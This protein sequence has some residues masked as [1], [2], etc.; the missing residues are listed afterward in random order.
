[1][2]CPSC[3]FDNPEGMKFC[4]QCAATLRPRCGR[5]GLENPPGFAFC[6]QCGISLTAKPKEKASTQAERRHL[7]VM[8]CDLVSSTP[9]SEQLD[10]EELREVMRAYQQACAEVIARFE[11]YLAKYLG[12]G[13]LVYFGYP[14][15]HEDDAQRAVRVGL[16]ILA[17]LPHLNVRLQQTGGAIR[18]WPL[19]V[20]IG[21]HTGLVVAGEMGGGDQREPLAIVGETPNIAARL[22]GVA[23]PDTVVISADTYRLTA[24]FFECRDLGPQQLKGV[25]LP[26][27]AY[28]VIQESGARSRFQA[29]AAT[30]L[31]P[32]VGRQEELGLLL[33]RWAQVK[34]GEGLVV[35]LSGEA[36][37]GKSR[38]VQA[39]KER[40]AKES[41]LWLECLCSPYHQNSALYP[42]IDLL[43][44]LLRFERADSLQEKF[45]KLAGVLQR[46]SLSL[47][48][49]VPLFASLL[50][51][52]LSDHYP[53]LTLAPQGRRQ[54]L[55]EALLALFRA[56]TEQQPVLQVVEDLHWADPST[57]ETLSFFVNHGSIA[58][59]LTLLTFRPEFSP[60]WVTRS[61]VTHLTLNR[62][63]HKQAE[64]MTVGVT[65][66]KT[67]PAEVTHELVT[68][69]DGVPLFVEELTKMVLESGWLKEEAN[70][71]TLTGSLPSV[72]IPAT[73]HDSLM[74]RL[75]RLG[76]VKEVAQLSATLGREFPYEL[77]K[78]IS[79]LDEAA[80]QSA[81]D[82]LVDAE[83]LYRRRLPSHELY[84]FKHA[85][86]QETAYQSLLKS[87]RQQSHKQIAQVLRE[88][89]QEVVEAQPE[90]LAYHYTEAGLFENAIPYW[91]EAGQRAVERSANEEAVSHLTKGLELLKALPDTPERAHQEL[92]LQAT[93]CPALIASKGYAAPEV[94]SACARARELSVQVGET[95]Q[96]FPVLIGL[97]SFYVAR[98][99]HEAARELGRQ[100][101]HLAQSVQDSA[102]LLWA[103]YVLGFT[104]FSLAELTP[105]REHSEQSIALYDPQ[106]HRSQALLYG[107]DPGV[108]CL[109]LSAWILWLL[110]YPDQARERIH[111]ALTLAR[112][113]SHPFSLAE[114]LSIAAV[115]HQFRREGQVVQLQAEAAITLSTDQGF[116]YWLTTGTFFRGWA[117]VTQGQGEE[118]I[119]QM[120]QGLATYRAMG[121]ELGRPHHLASL[122]ESY[123]KVGQAE[124]G[125]SVLT[126]ALAAV[127]KTGERFYEA[128][129]YRLKGELLLKQS[130]GPGAESGVHKEAEECF[131]RAIDIARRQSGKSLELRAVMSLSRL[132][133]RQGKG[134]EA[135]QM[136]AEIYGWFTE[137]FDTVDLKEAKSL[138]EELS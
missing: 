36:G 57:L 110:G 20:R 5:C 59:S 90:L 58:R 115:L 40:L 106:K 37:I 16:G 43:Q 38:L 132:W 46:F 111:H 77:L 2:R 65:K 61:H 79:S 86:I 96:L 14:T 33:K 92:F 120:R 99:E 71:Y 24:G 62:L 64:A 55:Q 75:D 85:L 31:T 1:M 6:G 60:P 7:T 15:A 93:L 118:G 95:P 117:L 130:G 68:K 74:A 25:S 41:H 54:K 70:R 44:R 28:Q 83:L 73:L 10:P 19:R 129:L 94:E 80:L 18:E 52:P 123:G 103:H 112:E 13:L 17:E 53:P 131:R 23:E 11:G 84:V 128:E 138:L 97:W 87:T 100:L 48:E 78:A 4:G 3:G 105:A 67:L 47:L 137:G 76:P 51:L 66:G 89:F 69:T 50:S 56:Q 29:S 134:E 124:E 133:R 135:R 121:A 72:G 81:L 125:L 91:Q 113:L 39:F 98:A 114:A 88:R 102:L 127:H 30:G 34:E 108:I 35:M 126:E 32:L 101:L 104:S 22:Q 21:I 63:S 109:G 122:A 9:L 45:N 119:A 12:D 116:P 26:V 8:F 42:V 136:L 27:L 107:E 49:T 82:Q